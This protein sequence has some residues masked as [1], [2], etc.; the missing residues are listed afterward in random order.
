MRMEL[1]QAWERGT[2]QE[3]TTITSVYWTPVTGKELAVIT[4]DNVHDC[5]TVAVLRCKII[6][7]LPTRLSWTGLSTSVPFS[8]LLTASCCH[9][10]GCGYYLRAGTISL[11]QR[12]CAGT[13]SL[14]QRNCAGTIQGQALFHVQV[15]CSIWRNTVYHF[16]LY[17]HW[18]YLKAVLGK[19]YRS[20]CIFM[21]P[22]KLY[23]TALIGQWLWQH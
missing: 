21:L 19:W 2:L 18:V 16:C 23:S 12:S 4:E 6:S 20:I 14:S 8:A 22:R 17:S 10:G 7:C 3:D 9:L 11:S 1:N 13:I 15:Q 5:H